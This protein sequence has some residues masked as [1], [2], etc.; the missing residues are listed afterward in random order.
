M[1]VETPNTNGSSSSSTSGVSPPVN[2]ADG[3]SSNTVIANRIFVGGIDYKVSEGDLRRIFSPHG[4]IREVKIVRDRS[5]V[6][7]GYG[8]VTFD[9]QEDALKI[10]EN[11]N[12]ICLKDKKLSIGQAFRRYQTPE[13]TQYAPVVSPEPALLQQVSCGTSYLT[14]S[15][16]YPYTYHNGVAYFHC[17]NMNPSVHHW[18]VAAPLM[19][20]QSHQPHQP[21]YQQPAYQYHQCVPNQHQWNAVQ[22]PTPS[23]SVVYSQQSEYLYQ[24]ADGGSLQLPVPVMEDTPPEVPTHQFVDLTM[25]HVYPVYPQRAEAMVPMVLQ[26]DIRKNLMFHPSRVH[27]KPKYRRYIHH[28]DFHHL[29]DSAEPPDSSV[30]H[31]F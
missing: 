27:L 26:H 29:P 16:G 6:V 1:E 3:S 9:S 11:A 31:T 20:P 22:L 10:L 5:G 24:P 17:P 21:V 12:E 14:T 19:S 4:T 30:F 8:F 15:T 2:P 18:P 25:Q 23:S 13:Q 7:K 28:K